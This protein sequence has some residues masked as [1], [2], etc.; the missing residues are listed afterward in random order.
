MCERAGGGGGGG[1]VAPARSRPLVRLR[2]RFQGS[3][4][5]IPS[6]SQALSDSSDLVHPREGGERERKKAP[7]A[8]PS[9]HATD[10]LEEGPI[11]AWKPARAWRLPQSL[12]AQPALLTGGKVVPRLCSSLPRAPSFPP[13]LLFLLLLPALLLPQVL[14]DVAG[15]SARARAP[16]SSAP[17]PA[18]SLFFL[19]LSGGAVG[20]RRA[21]GRL[22]PQGA[23]LGKL[24]RSAARLT[25]AF[26][27]L[28]GRAGGP[29]FP[30]RRVPAP[31]VDPSGD[32]GGYA[33]GGAE[34]ARA[35]VGGCGGSP[36]APSHARSPSPPSASSAPPRSSHRHIQA[37]SSSSPSLTPRPLSAPRPHPP[38]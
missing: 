30:T 22:P 19:P 12:P 37:C 32:A 10:F 2:H 38:G 25:F 31:A 1:G 11:L 14:T 8:L 24:G 23:K 9:S 34:A 15:L 26:S 18:P 3:C 20:T 35:G 28:P 4:N 29:R 21:A 27:L 13:L 7:T 33:G 16:S 5:P 17:A 36:G 6:D